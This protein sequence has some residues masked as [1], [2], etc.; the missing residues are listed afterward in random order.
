[1]E[2]CGMSW[3]RLGIGTER[4][5]EEVGMDHGKNRKARRRLVTLRYVAV[6]LKIYEVKTSVDKLVKP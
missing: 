3:D 6:S 1:M 2:R 5:T 4:K